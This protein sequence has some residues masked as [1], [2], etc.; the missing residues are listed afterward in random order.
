MRKM[1]LAIVLGSAMA[2]A[3]PALAMARTHHHPRHHSARHRHTRVRHEHFGSRNDDASAPS[4]TPTAGTIASFDNGLLT[5]KLGDGSMVSGR[6]TNATEIRC[7]AAEPG[8]MEHPEHTDSDQGGG[9]DNG[10]GGGDD[11]GD[12]N[13]RGDDEQGEEMCSTAN[14]VRTAVVSDAELTISGAGAI[15]SEVDLAG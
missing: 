5:I 12:N 11:N 10:N 9:S 7:E 2:A 6:V 3:V 8:E 13:D 4:N 15:W 14:L 1:L